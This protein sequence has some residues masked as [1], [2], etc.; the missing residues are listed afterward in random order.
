MLCCHL[1]QILIVARIAL[2]HARS[3]NPRLSAHDV[4]VLDVRIRC[5]MTV[6]LPIAQGTEM[7]WSFMLPPRA[8]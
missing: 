2:I 6:D 4:L 1:M 8:S 5:D 7:T 3:F